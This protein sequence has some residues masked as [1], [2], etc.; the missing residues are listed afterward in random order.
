MGDLNGLVRVEHSVLVFVD[1]TEQC[2]YLHVSFAAV[3]EHLQFQRWLLW[4]VEVFL[5]IVALEV[6]DACFQ[7]DRAFFKDAKLLVAHGHVMECEQENKLVARNLVRLDLVQHGLGLL[8][9][10]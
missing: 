9:K 4:V 3:L 8:K 10:Y 1:L 7:A 2:T 5:K 6:L